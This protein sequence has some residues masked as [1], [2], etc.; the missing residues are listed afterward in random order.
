MKNDDYYVIAGYIL[1]YLYSCLKEGKSP[2][3]SVL[4]LSAYPADIPNSYRDYVYI[5]LE[6]G[7]YITGVAWGEISAIGMKET[8]ILKSCS[9]AQIT[10][11]GIEYLQSDRSVE[12][13]L[14]IVEKFA[15]I[16]FSAI[17]A[18]R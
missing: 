6:K 2:E 13:A 18:F 8:R 4:N 14:K 5:Q 3:E 9:N 7:G 10:P 12:K 17:G 15:G 16:L 11:K 1:L